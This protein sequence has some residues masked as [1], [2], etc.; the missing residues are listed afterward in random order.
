MLCRS[1]KGLKTAPQVETALATARGNYTGGPF[2]PPAPRVN[3]KGSPSLSEFSRP[4]CH[5]GG[6]REDTVFGA[7]FSF[8]VLSCPALTAMP[9]KTR[10]AAQTRRS[11]RVSAPSLGSEPAILM[12]CLERPKD[13]MSPG[14]SQI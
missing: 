14:T 10:A 1:R 5:R 3:S 4:R 6:C 8:L 2:V 13:A 12:M 7:P 11:S 9:Q